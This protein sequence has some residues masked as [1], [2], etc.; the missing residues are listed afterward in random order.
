MEGKGVLFKRFADIDVFDIEIDSEDPD[1]IIRFC[2]LIAPTFG[3]IN[4]EDI[5]APEC[6]EIETTPDR[7]PRHPGLPRRPAR[8]RD[9]L[10]RRAAERARDR[11]QEDRATCGSSS[12]GAGAAGDRAARGSTRTSACGREHPDVRHARACST[13]GARDGHEPRTRRSSCASTQLPHAGRRDAR[14]RRLRRPLAGGP[15]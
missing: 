2:Q 3:G 8:H 9:H 11:R 13:R 12:R 6:F 14:R 15:A 4:L 1:E 7:D 10:G 5:R